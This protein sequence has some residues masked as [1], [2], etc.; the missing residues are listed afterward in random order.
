MKKSILISIGIA[1]ILVF[2]I[3]TIDVKAQ[4]DENE[5]IY[6]SETQ[7]VGDRSTFLFNVNLNH[8]KKIAELSY[9]PDAGHDLGKIPFDRAH[10]ACTPDGKKLYAVDFLDEDQTEHSNPTLGYLEVDNSSWHEIETV[11]IDSTIVLTGMGQAAFSP[12]GVLYVLSNHTDSLYTVDTGTAEATLVG[13][14]NIDVNGAD[15]AFAEDGILFLYTNSTKSTKKGLYIVTLP[16]NSLDAIFLGSSDPIDNKVTGLAIR[17]NGYGDLLGSVFGGEIYVM[18]K[19]NGLW[20]GTLPIFQMKHNDKNFRYQYGDM[21]LGPFALCTRS[22]G[23]WKK[24]SWNDAVIAIGSIQID[25]SL[26][27]EILR[28]ARGKNFS[29]LFAQLIAAKLNINNSTGI[30][31]IDDAEIWLCSQPDIING[32]LSLNWDKDFDSKQ[33]KREAA[34]FWEALGAFN[35]MYECDED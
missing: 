1:L 9:L 12:D 21:S 31:I 33:Q 4:S 5:V 2:V 17:A 14:L 20:G 18:D 30:P 10:L 6:L 35:D 8:A 34:K 16:P 3:L 22:I 7:P 19:S 13:K 25:E 26:G 28:N 32:D 23:Y 29:M 24:H 15:I 11:K 27:N